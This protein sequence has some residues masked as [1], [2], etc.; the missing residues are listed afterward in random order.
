M[1]RPPGMVISGLSGMGCSTASAGVASTVGRTSDSTLEI[2][3]LL[4]LI[5]EQKDPVGWYAH[6]D[7]LIEIDVE[8][9]V[10]PH[11]QQ[12]VADPHADKRIFARELGGIDGRGE[13]ALAGS[14]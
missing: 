9:A 1:N 13:I 11:G 5:V 4:C 3:T 7:Q 14:V 8:I 2:H 6:P 10:G 12:I